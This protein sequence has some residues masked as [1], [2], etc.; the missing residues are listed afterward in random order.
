MSHY[1][2]LV[3]LGVQVMINFY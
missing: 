3:V 2:S 1:T